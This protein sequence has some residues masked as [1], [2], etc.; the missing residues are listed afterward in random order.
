MIRNYFKI[1]LRNILRNKAY[2]LINIV[3]LT[4]GISSCCLLFMFVIDEMTYDSFHSKKDQIYRLIEVDNS[5]EATR[6]YAMTSPPVAHAMVDD[7][8][9]VEDAT[10]L[11]RFGGHINFN[12]GDVKYQERD[13]YI[14]DSNFFEVFDFELLYGDPKSALSK[15]D[16][17]V[18]D[19]EWS[20]ILFKGE[21]P[22][23]KIISMD[24]GETSM[25]VT[26]VLKEVPQNSHI[27]MRILLSLPT[28][29]ERLAPY[30]I[31]WEH[32]G[33]S[34]YV[35]LKSSVSIDYLESQMPEFIHKYFGEESDR[36]IQFQPLT[37]IHFKSQQIEFGADE[38]KGQF[39]YIY[40]FMAIGV[41][42]LLIACI[43]YMNLA[44]AKSLHRAKEIGMR[45]VSGAQKHQLI[46]QFLSESTLMAFIA[47]VFSVGLVDLVLPTFNTI[48][49]KNFVF[50]FSTLGGIFG[51][52]LVI[53]LIVGLLSG[54]YPAWMISKLKPANILKGSHQSSKGSLRLRQALVITQFTLSIIMIVATIVA[55]N[56]LNYIQSRS[57]G[58]SNEQLV[59]V[60]I[61]NGN[62]RERFETM[63]NEFIKSPYISKVAVSSRVPGEW[64]NLREVFARAVSSD[65]T[66]SVKT[67]YIGFDKD[68]ID[69]YD[70][71][72]VAGNNFTGNV[73]SDSLTVM[74][75]QT[76]AEMLGLSD[77]I[78]QYIDISSREKGQFRIVGVI[79]N[80][81]FQSLH[82][83]IRPMIL[84][85]RSNNIQSIDYFTLKIDADH[86]QE[87]IAHATDV[88]NAFD[89]FTPIEYHFLEEQWAQFYNND[90]RAGNIFAIG[91]GI[92]ILIACLG[93][94]GLASFIVQRRTK[95]IGVRK[96]LGASM[97]DLF[98][99]LSKTFALQVVIAFVIAAP[100]S[101]YFMKGWLDNFAFK[102]ELGITQFLLAGG[103]ALLIAIGSVSYRV[104]KASMIN[105]ANTLK[106]E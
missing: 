82:N 59:T 77:P 96:V 13:Y 4:L 50:D 52:L 101:W 58:F 5:E 21:N 2:S 76:A 35:V 99:L 15:P 73:S 23:G 56:Q 98:I 104:I 55:T 40:I 17:I 16:A 19:Q 87:A 11:F 88:H 38:N 69:T 72:L 86:I 48:T 81:N 51:L 41:F 64:K 42:M 65:K 91:A 46:F 10:R 75:N 80:F 90:R 70:M 36:K 44:T 26:G 34:A 100:I 1:A 37:D 97:M 22:L 68:M 94:I 78:G 7:Y 93:L 95:E 53:T 85:Y 30:L 25:V 103:A 39:E 24:N 67:Y 84:G 49:D 43:N 71:Q 6:Y 8:A 63:K 32:Y 27:Q 33:A 62:V 66:D 89:E 102:F 47:F 31:S 9:E 60:D 29:D 61:N 57:L 14:A 74:I 20:E 79:K 28:N 106:D 54:S 3:G 105:P 83:E 45:K 12:Q 18:I 92:T